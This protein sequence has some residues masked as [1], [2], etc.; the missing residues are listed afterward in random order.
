M[1]EPLEE[2]WSTLKQ[3]S[4]AELD[5]ETDE[6]FVATSAVIRR[7]IVELT[8]RFPTPVAVSSHSYPATVIQTTTRKEQTM[9]ALMV[10]AT[11][12]NDG[13]VVPD[14]VRMMTHYD[15]HGFP[16]GN[17]VVPQA[18]LGREPQTVRVLP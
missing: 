6:Q 12:G 1:R 17:A 8:Q 15:E 9:N 16:G 5:A 2:M 3:V 10:G 18:I 13:L 14:L 11:G 4:T 7:A